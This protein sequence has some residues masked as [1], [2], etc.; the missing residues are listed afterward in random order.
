MS[1]AL[2]ER[3]RAHGARVVAKQGSRRMRVLAALLWPINRAFMGRYWTTLGRTVYYPTSV[4]DPFAHADILEH[5]LVHVRQW[6]RFGLWM[7]L[8]YLLLP[9]PFGLAWFRFRWEREA[10]L[11]EISRAE[12]RERE[13]DR[14]VDALWHGYGWPWPRSLMRRWFQHH[15]PRAAPNGDERP[16]RRRPPP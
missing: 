14:V 8:S 12:D 7:W 10:Y 3:L 2:R 16:R 15:A 13:I 11:V 1:E 9:L 6:Q 5:E 4:S